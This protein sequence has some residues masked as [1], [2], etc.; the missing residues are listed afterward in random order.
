MGRIFPL[1]MSAHSSAGESGRLQLFPVNETKA[2]GN[3]DLGFLLVD[4][5]PNKQDLPGLAELTAR[6]GCKRL[7]L[8]ARYAWRPASPR[9]TR[10]GQARPHRVWSGRARTGWPGMK[11][12]LVMLSAPAPC[13]ASR[14]AGSRLPRGCPKT[15]VALALNGVR[16][17]RRAGGVL[18][19]F[20]ARGVQRRRNAGEA[21][22]GAAQGNRLRC[23]LRGRVETPPRSHPAGR[24]SHRVGR[25]R[26][27]L[28]GRWS[29]PRLDSRLASVSDSGSTPRIEKNALIVLAGLTQPLSQGFASHR[30]RPGEVSNVLR[31]ARRADARR[32]KC[33][34]QDRADVQPIPHSASVLSPLACGLESPNSSRTRSLPTP[35]PRPASCSSTNGLSPSGRE[36]FWGARRQAS[37]TMPD[38]GEARP[39]G[40]PRIGRRR[41]ACDAAAICPRC[42]AQSGGLSTA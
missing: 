6:G 36:L 12:T 7:S 4:R 18:T 19:R 15:T 11:S 24:R 10:E 28:S 39:I 35:Q 31:Q 17:G 13:S 41:P 25:R 29:R 27:P 34:R 30:D 26:P 23:D 42:N 8:R 2:H 16:A 9:P 38:L 1:G 5:P 33:K 22:A 14:N 37:G 40:R 21:V 20:R 3:D 32:D